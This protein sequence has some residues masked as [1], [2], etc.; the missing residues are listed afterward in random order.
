MRIW[1]IA[2]KRLCRNHLLEENGTKFNIETPLFKAYN[3]TCGGERCVTI[4]R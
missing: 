3:L 2:P 4:R 1:D